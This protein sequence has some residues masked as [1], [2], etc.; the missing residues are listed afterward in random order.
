MP[1]LEAA[2]RRDVKAAQSSRPFAGTFGRIAVAIPLPSE[3]PSNEIGVGPTS[4]CN[5]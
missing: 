4:L 2:S 3:N 5:E 1:T